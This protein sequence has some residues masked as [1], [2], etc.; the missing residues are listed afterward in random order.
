[1]KPLYRLLPWMIAGAASLLQAQEALYEG[2]RCPPAEARPFVRWWWNGN[3]L[4]ASELVR[5]LD[6]LHS[7]GVGGIEINPVAMPLVD[8]Q[9]SGE[10][11]TWLSPEW[12]GMLGL[13]I[14]EARKRG[15]IVD[16][17]AGTGWPFGGPFIQPEESLQRVQCTVTQVLLPARLEGAIP[18]PGGPHRE[19]LQL[20]LVPRHA[21]AIEQVLDL[22]PVLDAEGQIRFGQL[23]TRLRGGE[24]L[25][26]AVTLQNQFRQVGQGAPG[27]TGLALDHYNVSTDARSGCAGGGPTPTPP[28]TLSPKVPTCSR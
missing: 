21:T 25:L 18:M 1:M 3:H 14:T 12:N 4:E 28:G 27:G 7:A 24:Y 5:Q 26:Y 19:L 8:R 9:P 23:K 20:R 2:F 13:A 15:M 22:M 11:L 16:L 17:L 10:G 6:V